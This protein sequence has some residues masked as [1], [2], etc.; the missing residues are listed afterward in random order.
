MIEQYYVIIKVVFDGMTEPLQTSPLHI[1][2]I[3]MF[4]VIHRLSEAS[5]RRSLVSQ[6]GHQIDPEE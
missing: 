4:D 3:E 6:L 1:C 5:G 2:G